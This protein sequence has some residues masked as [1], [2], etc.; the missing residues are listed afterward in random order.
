[1]NNPRDSSPDKPSSDEQRSNHD[2]PQNA[3]DE[4]IVQET[5]IGGGSSSTPP[6]E[7]QQTG[8]DA[9]VGFGES[10]TKLVGDEGHDATDIVKGPHEGS[11]RNRRSHNDELGASSNTGIQRPKRKAELLDPPSCDPNCVVCGKQ[12]G[13]W[14]AVFGHMRSHPERQWR[15]VFP[16]P[17]GNWDP[18]ASLDKEADKPD[19]GLQAQ[20][21]I[22]TTLLSVAQGVLSGISTPAALTTNVEKGDDSAI[23]E[24]FKDATSITEAS[25]S[26][27]MGG[28]G[29]DLNQPQEKDHKPPIL[30]LNVRP[31][32]RDP[33]IVSDDEE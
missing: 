11:L 23:N 29:I 28:L 18:L 2:S 7:A 4:A 20:E 24:G 25:S 13:S 32:E 30:D 27:P 10:M 26:S 5:E 17:A 14:K 31:T 6:R 16:P 1:M 21:E 9:D 19:I 12:F 15:G 8:D 3:S 22:A 33:E